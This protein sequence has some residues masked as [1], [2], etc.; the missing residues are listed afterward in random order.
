M[1]AKEKAGMY[2]TR[3]STKNIIMI[4]GHITCETAQRL[5]PLIAVPTNRQ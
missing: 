1:N 4:C 2:V 3:I 5:W